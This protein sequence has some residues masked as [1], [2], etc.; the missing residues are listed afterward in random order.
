MD[1]VF[2]LDKIY[3]R[4]GGYGMVVIGLFWGVAAAD[5]FVDMVLICLHRM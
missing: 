2:M 4:L 5:S 3:F 1:C